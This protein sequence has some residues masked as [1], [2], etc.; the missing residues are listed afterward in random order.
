MKPSNLNGGQE[1]LCI[2]TE[3]VYDWIINDANFDINLASITLPE[4]VLCDVVNDIDVTCNVIPTG[5]EIVDREDQEFTIDGVDITLQVVTISKG[6]TVELEFPVLDGVE[7]FTRAFTRTEQVV[8]C[9]PEGTEI[10]IEFTE[11]ECTIVSIDCDP[12]ALTFDATISVRLCQSIQSVY[13]VTLELVADF[14][15]PR[16]EVILPTGPCPLPTVPP[17][18]P[19]LFPANG[20]NG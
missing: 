5:V 3:K 20:E 8:L 12:D 16:E 1:L 13:D 10:D 9:A 4:G 6:F 11:E 17:Q 2:N 7:V 14:C 19:E 18:C 15:Q